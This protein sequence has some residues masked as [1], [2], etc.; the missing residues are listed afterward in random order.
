MKLSHFTPAQTCKNVKVDVK[1]H[2]ALAN[3]TFNE[4]MRDSKTQG[5]HFGRM[6]IFGFSTSPLLAFMAYLG[7][8]TMQT[9]QRKEGRRGHY[10]TLGRA[11]E[12]KGED[13]G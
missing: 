13:G 2:A 11:K 9:G 1:A 12:A 4:F 6:Q 3:D 7:N 10:Y 5:L 8:G